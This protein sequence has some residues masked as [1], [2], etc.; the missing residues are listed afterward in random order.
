MR[1]QIGCFKERNPKLE[2]KWLWVQHS[3]SL[4]I[5]QTQGYVLDEDA[6]KRMGENLKSDFTDTFEI[7]RT[8]V[9]KQYLY[10]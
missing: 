1:N 7:L 3:I 10:Q 6:Q 4:V 9:S 8:Q 2:R 5:E